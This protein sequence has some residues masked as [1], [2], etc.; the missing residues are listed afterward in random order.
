MNNALD[1]LHQAYELMKEA[2]SLVAEV[3]TLSPSLAG[4]YGYSLDIIEQELHRM[5]DNHRGYLGRNTTLLEIIEAEGRKWHN[6]EP[7]SEDEEDEEDEEEFLF[8]TY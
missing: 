8:A 5:S 4:Y 1:K 6:S 2:E 3:K 7:E